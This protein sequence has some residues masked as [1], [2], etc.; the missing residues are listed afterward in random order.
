L[1]SSNHV[2]PPSTLPPGST[3]WAYLRDSGGDNQDRSISRQL[4]VIESYC[5]L[6]E[7]E[8]IHV[9]KDEAKSGTSTAGRED[10][11]RMIKE[12]DNGEHNPHGLL[13]WSFS[14]FGR[15]LEDSTYYK[16]RL[17]RNGITIHSL[18]D[19]IPE[20]KFAIFAEM[21]IDMANEE[22]SEQTAI[23]ARDGLRALVM[24]GAMPGTPPRGFK[25][26]PIKTIN[27]RKGETRTNHR[28]VPDPKLRK[29]VLKAWSMKASGAPV[30]EIHKATR[31]FGSTN[32]YTTFF[33]NKL[34]IGILEF[35][36]L[37]VENY[38][39]ALIDMETW[40]AVQKRSEDH[41]KTI[42]KE[43]HP[44]RT[45]S[46]YLLSGYCI[47]ARCEAPMNGNTTIRNKVENRDEGYRCSRSKRHAGCDA[48]R[49][50]R[51]RLEELVI[52]TI[53]NHILAPDNIA[54]IQEIAIENQTHGEARR[55]E[56]RKELHDERASVARAI[57][58]YTAA[59]GEM[60]LSTAIAKSLRDAEARQ[61]EIKKELE[62]LDIPVQA[63]P[64]L[65]Y[66]QIVTVSKTLI[67][68][69]KEAPYEDKRQYLK[70][71][72]HKVR[73]ERV[74]DKIF[75]LVEYYYPF[76]GSPPFESAPVELLPMNRTPMGAPLYRQLFSYPAVV[77]VTKTRS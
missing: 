41:A 12:S 42:F 17:R 38:C 35:G 73:A 22:R 77:T 65:T 27:P 49:V 23:D 54:A 32:S 70:E 6:H 76:T 4:E 26:E 19:Q 46:A 31:I 21:F 69:I 11:L 60:G 7:L 51:R 43:S 48:G 15:N 39:E 40:N 2:P 56:R 47:C 67:Q 34:F 68:R 74:G 72:I 5:K 52:D 63:V 20:G 24:Q 37:V 44:K 1:S 57:A 29:R 75:C 10:F 61:A 18:T 8:L 14:R 28:W 59:I 30:A 25:R 62:E 53:E 3:V 13:L 9:Y 64:R 45:N 16:Q 55:T 36:D 50:N 33:R 58:N 66:D 71:L